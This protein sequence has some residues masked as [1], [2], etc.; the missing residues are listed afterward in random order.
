MFLAYKNTN[1]KKTTVDGDIRNNVHPAL[2]SPYQFIFYGPNVG[3]LQRNLKSKALLHI[4]TSFAQSK[5]Q[6]HK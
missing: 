3:T 6:C 5:E 4:Y 2:Q 1:S